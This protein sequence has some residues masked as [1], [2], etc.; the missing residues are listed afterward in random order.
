MGNQSVHTL[1]DVVNNNS[2]ILNAVD[3]NWVITEAWWK[4]MMREDSASRF[5]QLIAST[6]PSNNAL[7]TCEESI[8]QMGALDNSH[9][10]EFLGLTLNRLT[11]RNQSMR[12]IHQSRRTSGYGY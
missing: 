2:L 6:L 3:R 5:Q 12:R 7:I 11:G 10:M 8:A 9:V 4:T 1:K